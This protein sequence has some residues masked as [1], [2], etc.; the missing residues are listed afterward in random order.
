MDEELALWQLAMKEQRAAEGRLAAVRRTR[1]VE[2]VRLH[3]HV[4][5]VRVRAALLLAK[6]VQTMR[7]EASDVDTNLSLL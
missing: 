5:A 4:E 2:S 7:D 1:S 6:A 3:R